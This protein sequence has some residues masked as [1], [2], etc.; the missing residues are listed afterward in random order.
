MAPSGRRIHCATEAEARRVEAWVTWLRAEQA[1][2]ER[3]ARENRQ[4]LPERYVRVFLEDYFVER[5]AP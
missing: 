1:A 5:G 4:P 2:R 3:R